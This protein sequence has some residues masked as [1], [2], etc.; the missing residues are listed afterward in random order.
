MR[1]ILSHLLQFQ[2]LKQSNHEGKI[3][4][5]QLQYLYQVFNNGE[6]WTKF[7]AKKSAN[8][9]RNLMQRSCCSQISG[10]EIMYRMFDIHSLMG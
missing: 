9:V 3:Q 5:N 7:T 6:E 4:T 8:H 1:S 10:D 2:L